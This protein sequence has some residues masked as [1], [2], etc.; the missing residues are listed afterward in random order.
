MLEN[1][2]ESMKLQYEIE[3]KNIEKNYDVLYNNYTQLQVDYANL[4]TM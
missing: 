1:N 3:V 4:M 2:Y